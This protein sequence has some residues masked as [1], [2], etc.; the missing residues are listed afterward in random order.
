MSNGHGSLSRSTDPRK[1]IPN[2]RVKSAM[3]VF[4]FRDGFGVV[5]RCAQ[6]LPEV[7]AGARGG[8]SSAELLYVHP[9]VD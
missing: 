6:M 2:R 5:G 3:P 1:T 4:Q 9:T 7:A 8:V